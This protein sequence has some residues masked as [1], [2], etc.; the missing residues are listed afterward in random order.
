MGELRRLHSE[1][2]VEMHVLARVREMVLAADDVRHVHRDVVDDIHEMEHRIAV[3]THDDEI[4]VLDA[5]HPA[6][7]AVLDDDRR[8]LH[9]RDG[10]LAV[11]VEHLEAL[12]EQPEPDRAVLFVGAAGRD[13]PGDVLLVDRAALAVPV[14]T[15]IASAVFTDLRALVPIEAEPAQAVVDQVEEGLAV[16][17]L[18]R[19]LDP[20]D[21]RAAGV[22]GIQPVEQRR[23]GAA[24][25]KKTGGTRSKTNANLRHEREDRITGWIPKRNG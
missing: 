21:E 25:V 20:Q 24:D 1:A 4:L 14:G 22:T 9:L 18:V 19:V 11:L 5:L 3:R 6:A 12:P 15:E 8:A 7:N 23:A 16:A 17:F 13:Q 10:L 2:L